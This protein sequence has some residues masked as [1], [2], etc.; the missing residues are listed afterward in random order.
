LTFLSAISQTSGGAFRSGRRRGT[1]LGAASRPLIFTV[2]PRQF[3]KS[4][5]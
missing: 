4:Q 2:L 5:A 1:S 3:R